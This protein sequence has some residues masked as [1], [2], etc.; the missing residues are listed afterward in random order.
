MLLLSRVCYKAWHAE[1]Q[2]EV[3]SQPPKVQ[4]HSMI[5][6][7]STYVSTPLAPFCA[8]AGRWRSSQGKHVQC[9]FP[10]LFMV[11]TSCFDILF[12][13]F[14]IV[15]S[16]RPPGTYW[17]DKMRDPENL[18]MR[19]YLVLKLP[20]IKFC[21]IIHFYIY[22]NNLQLFI[23]IW[24]SYIILENF[25][26]HKNNPARITRSR[27]ITHQYTNDSSLTPR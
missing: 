2:E 14:H 19:I 20:V 22:I 11:N 12:I 8:A 15:S 25:N 10:T 26:D 7:V 27:K 17:F 18:Y 9:M 5:T 24:I 13:L 4:V 1:R 6:V 16:W 21:L 23:S 3:A